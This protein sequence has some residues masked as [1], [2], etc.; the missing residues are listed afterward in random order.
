MTRAEKDPGNFD[1][2]SAYFPDIS[3]KFPYALDITGVLLKKTFGVLE[4]NK[5][6][7]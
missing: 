4:M 2:E 6:C 5:R 1:S 7:D 3:L